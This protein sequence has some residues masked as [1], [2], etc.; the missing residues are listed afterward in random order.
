MGLWFCLVWFVFFWG[1]GAVRGFFWVSGHMEYLQVHL[2]CL[3]WQ[4]N[5]FCELSALWVERS[6][7][8]CCEQGETLTPDSKQWRTSSSFH[9]SILLLHFRSF[10]A[11]WISG[12]P[13]CQGCLRSQRTYTVFDL[14]VL[15]FCLWGHCGSGFKTTCETDVDAV[16]HEL[17]PP[18]PPHARSEWTVQ[19]PRE[20]SRCETGGFPIPLINKDNF[21]AALAS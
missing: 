3:P 8:L 15:R 18:P 20:C 4:F 1:G 14:S 13:W 17:L 7:A 11:A 21:Q 12:R 6:L 19:T 9:L 2:C 5:V 10:S 16:A